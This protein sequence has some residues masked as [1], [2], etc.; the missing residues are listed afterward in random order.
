MLTAVTSLDQQL[1]GVVDN[2]N[3]HMNVRPKADG[4]PVVSLIYRTEPKTEKK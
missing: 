3:W 4:Y 1:T 2:L